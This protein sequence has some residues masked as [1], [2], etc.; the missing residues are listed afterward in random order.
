[1]ELCI[2]VAI[3]KGVPIQAALS[4]KGLIDKIKL[5]RPALALNDYQTYQLQVDL[6]GEDV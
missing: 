6:D 1:M 4:Y 2:W 3:M 5:K